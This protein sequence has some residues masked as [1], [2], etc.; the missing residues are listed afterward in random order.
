[1]IPYIK[2]QSIEKI[3]RIYI[4]YFNDLDKHNILLL[5]LSFSSVYTYM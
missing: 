2:G 1:M 3:L 4:K 5:S